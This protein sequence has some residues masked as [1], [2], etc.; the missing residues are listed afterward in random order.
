LEKNGCQVL[1]YIKVANK[2]SYVTTILDLADRRIVA[3]V[4][5]DDMTTENTVYK[6]WILAR[7]RETLP[8]TTFFIPT[9]VS[10]MLQIKW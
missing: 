5:S 2:W 8:I 1:P 6:A 3:W 10:N 4:L 9:E 7:K